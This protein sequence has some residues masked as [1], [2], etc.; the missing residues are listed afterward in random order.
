MVNLTIDDK[1][2]TVPRDATIYD[3][4]KACAGLEFCA[5]KQ[6]TSPVDGTCH[7]VEGKSAD[8]ALITDPNQC[9]KPPE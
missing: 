4:A 5:W 9:P 3:A 1:Q 7:Y 8:P 2:V 6:T